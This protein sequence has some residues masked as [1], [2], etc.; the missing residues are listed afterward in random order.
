MQY[1]L[2][3]KQVRIFN[4]SVPAEA[5]N[6]SDHLQCI[7]VK[8]NVIV[9]IGDTIKGNA[10]STINAQG[11]ALAPGFI[12]VHTH[13]DIFAIKHPDML[14]K[15]SQGVTTVIVGNCGLSAAP[16]SFC[17]EALITPPDPIN[18]LG[19]I[20]DFIYPDFKSYVH[21]VEKAKPAV[22]VAALV[23]HTSLRASVMTDLLKPANA[24]QIEK[25]QTLLKEAMAA[26]ALGLS[27]GLAYMNAKQAPT[28]EVQALL[29]VMAGKGIYT[30]H[31]RTE[32]DGIIDAMDE[33]YQLGEQAKLPVQISH[34][35]C[36]GL[37]NWGRSKELLNS[38][39]V[40][41]QKGLPVSCDCYPYAASS[42]TLDLNQVTDEF[43]IF[44]TWSDGEPDMAGQTLLE[45][46]SIWNVD[47]NAAAQ[48]LMPA[49]AVYHCMD[50]KDVETILR[51]KK[52][53]IGSDGLPNDP[54]PHPRLW[55]SFARVLGYFSREKGLFDLHTAIHKMTGLPASTFKLNNRGE[56]KVGNFADLVLFDPN[57]VKDAA[58]F[59]QPKQTAIGIEKVWVNGVLSY[60]NGQLSEDRSGKFLK[61]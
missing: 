54:H 19:E 51:H 36:A 23:G 58:T 53:M 49:G 34:L 30:T 20:K 41:A 16:V 21:A 5:L 9:A 15:L 26:G 7:A 48:R 3:I 8:D 18:L 47:L 25:M 44:I 22:N 40:A 1:D 13:D 55:G 14:N 35:K 29:G 59:H 37:G 42:S 31:L 61:L 46:A 45:I 33:A 39:D 56:I 43:D 52:T 32:F 10:V 4:G 17:D 12:D 28:A 50:E 11:L 57:T 27:S 24:D 2:L 60:E 38:V 6:N